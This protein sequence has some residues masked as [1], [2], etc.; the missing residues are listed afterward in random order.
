MDYTLP[1][2]AFDAM[3]KLTG[4]ELDLVYDKEMYDTNNL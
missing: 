1:N 2:F 3:L 4:V